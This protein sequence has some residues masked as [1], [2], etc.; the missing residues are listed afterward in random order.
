VRSQ[1]AMRRPRH[2]TGGGSVADAITR[3]VQGV[4]LARVEGDI[5]HQPDVD[6]GVNAANAGLRIGGG[7]PEPDG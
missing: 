5:A 1:G 6:A 4:T 7:D 3:N 2:G